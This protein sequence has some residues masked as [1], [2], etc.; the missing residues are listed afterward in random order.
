M[1]FGY[2]QAHIC[3]DPT[4]FVSGRYQQTQILLLYPLLLFL[5]YPFSFASNIPDFH[6]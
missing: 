2:W 6:L 5:F 4:L 3:G 1:G